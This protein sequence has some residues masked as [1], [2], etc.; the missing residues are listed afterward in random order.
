MTKTKSGLA[1]RDYK[2]VYVSTEFTLPC[3]LIR[4]HTKGLGI[5]TLVSCFVAR[6]FHLLNISGFCAK[7]S[8]YNSKYYFQYILTWFV[9]IITQTRRSWRTHNHKHGAAGGRT[10]T[11]TAHNSTAAKRTP[12]RPQKTN[13]II[14]LERGIPEPRKLGQDLEFK[15]WL[16]LAAFGNSLML[17]K[18]FFKW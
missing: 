17:F 4:M 10:T 16:H 3:A 9:L 2:F 6:C 1:T 13:S 15:L 18:F 7:M 11:N 14:R 12:G 8:Q 5:L